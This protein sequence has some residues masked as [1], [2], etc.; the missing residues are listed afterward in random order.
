MIAGAEP[1]AYLGEVLAM[2]SETRT[3]SIPNAKN[4][5]P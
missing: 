5:S 1:R 4:P 3:S 2:L